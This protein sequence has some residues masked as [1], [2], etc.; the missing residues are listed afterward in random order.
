MAGRSWAA[1]AFVLAMACAQ[2]TLAQL[3]LVAEPPLIQAIRQNDLDEVRDALTLGRS[4][5]VTSNNGTS[6]L[7]IAVET[8]SAAIV[9]ELLEA[10][11][12]PGLADRT[13][14]TPLH[15]A[16]RRDRPD[17]VALLIAHGA[18]VDDANR[19]GLTA[20]MTAARNECPGVA[21]VL[22]ANGADPLATD[23]TGR[24]AEDWAIASRST[25]TLQ[26]L[27]NR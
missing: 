20:L 12:L 24:T 18:D 14:E 1:V 9:Q 6:A 15:A 16:A 19:Q 25:R 21:E 22:L 4:A 26:V 2:G 27:Q 8:A 23:F 11:A 10:G 5:R 17:V 3:D 7:T 13:G